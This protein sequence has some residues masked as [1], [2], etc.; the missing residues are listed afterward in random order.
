MA[1][2]AFDTYTG[3]DGTPWSTGIWIAGNSTSGSSATLSGNQGRLD[4]GSVTG[5][6][7]KCARR[8][9]GV[10]VVEARVRTRVAFRFSVDGAFRIYLRADDALDH[11]T[12]YVIILDRATQSVG[13]SRLVNYSAT[14]IGG[15]S[16]PYAIAQDVA[17]EVDFQALGSQIKLWVWPVGDAKPT[18]PT[19]S[20]IDTAVTAP[21]AIGLLAVGGGSGGFKVDVD[22]FVATDGQGELLVTGASSATGSL[23]RQPRR[24]FAGSATGGGLLFGTKVVLRVFSSSTVA[25]GTFVLARLRAFAGTTTAAGTVLRQPQRIMAGSSSA[26]G[27]IRRGFL[28]VLTGSA[29]ATGALVSD[30]LGRVV[31]ESATVKMTVS[32]LSWVRITVRRW[33]S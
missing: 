26:T 11:Q 27:L 6:E 4:A 29:S 9:T 5:Y 21:G 28:R 19:I 33:T 20:A 23:L 13:M 31:G 30:F 17:H 15:G 16:K 18:S 7:G 22:D 3:A 25:S 8:L 2:Y 10:S 12:G 32:A 1:T 14:P 24:R